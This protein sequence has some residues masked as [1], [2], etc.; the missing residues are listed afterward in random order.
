MG[1]ETGNGLLCHCLCVDNIV[2]ALFELHG[3]NRRGLG[4]QSRSEEVETE[5]AGNHGS[6][7]RAFVETRSKSDDGG[8]F[9]AMR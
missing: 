2:S 7:L 6:K 3:V 5:E 1:T 9:G 4:R 8:V